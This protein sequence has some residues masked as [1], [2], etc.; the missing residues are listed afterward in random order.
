GLGPEHIDYVNAHATST[1]IGD[2]QKL[3]QLTGC[4][5]RAVAIKGAKFSCPPRRGPRG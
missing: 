4:L 3:L 5:S 2:G 1:P